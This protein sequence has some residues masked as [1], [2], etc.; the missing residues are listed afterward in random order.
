[1]A[2]HKRC[3][4]MG[5][6]GMSAWFLSGCAQLPDWAQ[7]RQSMST[8]ISDPG[9]PRLRAQMSDAPK[10]VQINM[11]LPLDIAPPKELERPAQPA[12]SGIQQTSLVSRGTVRVRVRAW[13]NG[14]PLFDNEVMQLAGPELSRLPVGLSSAERT[15]KMA[16][17]VNNAIEQLIDQEIMYQDA[18]KK[19]EK[20]NPQA[21]DKLKE[22]VDLE[23]DKTL[24]RMRQ[25]N[26]P[27]SDI[28]EI[29]PTLRRMTERNLVSSE[30]ARSRI[31]P[32]IETRIGLMEVREYYETHLSEFQSEDKVYW[33]DVFIPLS[34][35]HPTIDALKLFAEGLANRCR[36]EDDFNK[37][38]AFDG[39]GKNGEG[40]GNR[41]GEI[42]PSELEQTLFEMEPGRIGPIIPFGSG[43][44]LIWVTKRERKGQL[45]LNDEVAKIIRRKLEKD[46]ADREYRRL[47]RELRVRAVWRIETDTQ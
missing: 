35:N 26:V 25:A 30:Y 13:V 3:L 36:N 15:Q 33:K 23:S 42:R 14:R 7:P 46:L 10:K 18:I 44:H 40:L 19:L 47:V 22:Y 8:L 4:G 32:L 16:E 38:I 1:M 20:A 27:E 12:P 31:R 21:L 11:P 43:V 24:D 5:M 41:R 9:E 2:W 17:V 45:P 37:L 34:P 6:V 29:E 39:L 28:R